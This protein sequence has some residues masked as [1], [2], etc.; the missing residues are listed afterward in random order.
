MVKKSI[1]K[2]HSVNKRDL[3]DTNN[4]RLTDRRVKNE[5]KE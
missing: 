1:R 3:W 2:K 4:K 5:T